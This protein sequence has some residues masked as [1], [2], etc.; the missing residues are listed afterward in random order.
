MSSRATDPRQVQPGEPR[1]EALRSP[2]SPSPVGTRRRLQALAARSWTPEAV[3]KETGIPA[4]LIRRELDGYDD[5]APELAGHIA[6]EYDRLWDREPPAATAKDR[7]AA[8]EIA[9]EAASRGWAP[10]MA[11]DDDRIDLPGGGPER[12]WRPRPMVYLKSRDLV[13]D[14]E[15]VRETNGLREASVAEVAA[16]LGVKRDRLEQAYVRT[17]RYAARNATAGRRGAE[18]AGREAEAG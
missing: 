15:F 7:R 5:L 10:P 12:G 9:A 13:E 18:D 3:E 4:R 16:R 2:V 11:W 17:R 14:A 6:G 1:L 8:D